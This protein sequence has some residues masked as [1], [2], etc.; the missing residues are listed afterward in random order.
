M[1]SRTA[2]FGLPEVKRGLVAAG[3]GLLRLPHRV[4]RALALEWALTGAQIPAERAAAA[5]L[6]NRLTEPG[7][8]VAS[9]LE[10]AQAIAANAPLAVR[11][12]NRS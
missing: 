9:A 4:P 12:T 10:L 8:A 6:I 2:V 3:C 11:A 5:G 7:E 1:A